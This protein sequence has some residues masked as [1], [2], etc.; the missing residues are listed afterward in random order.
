MDTLAVTG[1]L[2]RTAVAALVVGLLVVAF[3]GARASAAEDV[4]EDVVAAFSDTALQQLQAMNA[5]DRAG[6]PAAPDLSIATGFGDVHRVHL[7]SA[8]LVTS[9]DTS[10]PVTALDEWVAPLLGR[11]ETP[12]GVYLVWREHA[13]AAAEF[14]GYDHDADAAAGLASVDGGIVVS[15]PT[16]AAWY[17]LRDGQLRGLNPQARVELPT[18][19]E[20]S[21][22]ALVI[23]ERHH[24][25]LRQSAGL[26]GAAGG[27]AVDGDG[28]TVAE[29]P[30]Y[31]GLNLWAIGGAVI[32]VVAGSAAIISF[33]RRSRRIT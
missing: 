30:W 11:D 18:P 19:E 22:F 10:D 26:E 14:A 23:S 9:A 31:S 20:L 6:D 8:S 28:S 27:S 32:L 4:P 7:W 1:M 13:G 17:E 16:I 2:K 29:R 5:E 3:G 25:T 15:D 21:A 33:T 24:E 12:V